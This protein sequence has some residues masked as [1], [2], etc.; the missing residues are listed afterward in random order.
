MNR[1][2]TVASGST[3]TEEVVGDALTIARARQVTVKGWQG[4]KSRKESDK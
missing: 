3:I 4:P 2:A 1:N